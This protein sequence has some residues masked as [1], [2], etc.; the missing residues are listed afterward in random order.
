METKVIR[1]AEIK[2]LS[3]IAEILVF[4]KRMNYRS[5][6]HND[7]FSFNN[8]QV[9]K[10]AEE[11]EK[12]EI[13]EHI[14]VY[15]DCFVK[16]MIHIE[17]KEIVEL[18]VD[19][20]FQNEGIGGELVEFAKKEFNA[21]H[22]WALEKNTNAIRFYEAHGFHVTDIRKPESNSSEYLVKLVR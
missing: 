8:L 13:L 2:D 11:Y 18:Y 16:G 22:L 3:R 1:K 15:D 6:F 10:V 5:I 17:E 19:V 21:D 7:E 9:L 14:W 20:F 12:P 4:V